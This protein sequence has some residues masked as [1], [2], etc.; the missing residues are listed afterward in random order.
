[1]RKTFNTFNFLYGFLGNTITIATGLTAIGKLGGLDNC[2]AASRNAG[3]TAIL[4]LFMFYTTIT[5]GVI[6]RRIVAKKSGYAELLDEGVM[7]G[8]L[9]VQILTS[10][11]FFIAVL[12]AAPFRDFFWFLE[13][14]TGI[15][16]LS[17]AF[18]QI[19][20]VLAFYSAVI[21]FCNYASEAIHKAIYPLESPIIF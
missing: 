4:I 19:S 11:L 18:F 7:R 8:I 16:E 17:N 15:L 6:A 1:M 5:V 12:F 3:M 13:D 9:F 14:Y 2:P 20:F 10:L 21:A